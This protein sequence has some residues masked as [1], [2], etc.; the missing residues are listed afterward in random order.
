MKVIP[1]EMGDI[2]YAR[3]YLEEGCLK[4][5]FEEV[6]K[7]HAVTAKK[8]GSV[9]SSAFAVWKEKG[10]ERKGQFVIKFTHKST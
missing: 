9:I 6:K 4:G 2:R 7:W 5:I 8:N 10:G 3:A 1:Q